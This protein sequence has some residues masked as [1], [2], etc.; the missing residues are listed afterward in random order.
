MKKLLKVLSLSALLSASLVV[1]SCGDVNEPQNSE[2]SNEPKETS[3]SSE[4]S[5][6]GST[7]SSSSSESIPDGQAK[8]TI[9]AKCE[10][11][12]PVKGASIIVTID[13][14]KKTMTTDAS[15]LAT[16]TADKTKAYKL[17][18]IEPEGYTLNE[19]SLDVIAEA[20]EITELYFT[21]YLV[22]DYESEDFPSSFAEY[23]QMYDYTFKG[24][25]YTEKGT[26]V[27]N[28]QTSIS[29]ELETHDAVVLNFWYTTCSWCIKEFPTL[30]SSYKSHSSNISL[31]EINSG[32][33]S[34]DDLSTVSAFMQDN[35]YEFF[36]TIG[37]T[38][39]ISSFSISG[40]PTTV[41]IDRYGTICYIDSGAIT[42]EDK[43]DAL[44]ETYIGSTYKQPYE[45][46]GSTVIPTTTFPGSETLANI[47]LAGDDIKKSATFTTETRENY[48][49]Y[50]WPWVA[51]SDNSAIVPSNT[52]T[53]SSYSILY[54]NVT[55]PAG[56][57]LTLDYMISSEDSDIFGV[58]VD[59]KKIFQDAGKSNEYV[60]KAIYVAGDSDEEITVEFVYQKDSKLGLYDDTVYVKNIR[61]AESDSIGEFRAIRQASY[62]E[63]DTM[64]N[65]WTKYVDVV[66]SKDDGYYHVGSANGPLLLAAL[67][68]SNTHFSSYS[69]STLLSEMSTED[70]AKKDSVSGKTYYSILSQYASYCGNSSVTM[71]D[72]PTDGLTSITAE[73]QRALVWVANTYGAGS[74]EDQWL[75]MCVYIDEYNCKTPLKDPIEGLAPFSAKKAY[76]ITDPSDETQSSYMNYVKFDFPLVPRGYYFSVTPSKSGVY[77]V[78]GAVKGQVTECFFYDE[79]GYAISLDTERSAYSNI[80]GESDDENFSYHLYYEA[81]HTYYVAPCFWD[82]NDTENTL[83]FKI[84]YVSD[85]Y[86]YLAQASEGTF[87][88]SED[89]S[90]NIT[91]YI[92]VANV[93]VS[94]GS[95]GYYHPVVNDQIQNDK[96]IYADFKYVTPI[97]NNM[98]LEEAID[99]TTG[100]GVRISISDSKVYIETSSDGCASYST[101]LEMTGDTTKLSGTYTFTESSK[102]Y[103]VV[104]DENNVTVTVGDTTTVFVIYSNKDNVIIAKQKSYAFDF[105]LKT[106]QS[107][108]VH[109][110]TDSNGN[111]QTDSDGNYISTPYTE[112]ELEQLFSLK[113]ETATIKK[114]L[115]ENMVTDTTSIYYGTVKVDSTLCTLLQQLMSKY[116]FINSSTSGSTTTYSHVEGAWLKLCYYEVDL[117][118]K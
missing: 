44:F 48:A 103:N 92:S 9:K 94:L 16:F 63:Q 64:L 57:A 112:A 98:G 105:T 18:V 86:T 32:S 79:N 52:G 11:G 109:Y 3:T 99:S 54:L 14:K 59:G 15:G 97:I 61:F 73:L 107:L 96:F 25:S 93:S 102:E 81:G 33:V 80:S 1:A 41:I 108:F 111:Y 2:S 70:K 26:K 118:N 104:I 95:D 17:N 65:E 101:A 53:N 106:L 30:L 40:Y 38:S 58:F 110:A 28:A 91:G 23:D 75:E 42:S 35:S 29:K 77:R 55:V 66:L 84:E 5:S 21:P 51:K 62:G 87:T 82:I 45:E 85:S 49:A 39:F 22:T 13:G 24:Y 69:I 113:D 67:M 89:S 43:W 4:A 20:D 88:Y 56:K 90:G 115:E 19:D 60:T 50:N 10:S 114:I 78:Y 83:G 46:T 74:N 71:L 31:I 36:T 100:Y 6:T 76:V 68:D 116:T 8:Y 37:D 47:A 72:M 27:E 12:K 34:N 117:S 7:E